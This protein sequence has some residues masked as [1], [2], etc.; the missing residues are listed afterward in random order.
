M[1]GTQADNWGSPQS[2]FKHITHFIPQALTERAAAEQRALIA[3]R[4]TK[5]NERKA[6]EEYRHATAAKKA[7]MIWAL[8]TIIINRSEHPYLARK[9]INPNGARLY[10]GC[11]V[12]A[13][14]NQYAE[15]INL[16]LINSDGSKKFL[17]RFL[18]G[19]RI[20]GCFGLITDGKNKSTILV[21]E[22]FSTGSS[23]FEAT[24]FYTIIALSARN[25][26][27]A[28]ILIAGL[29][30]ESKIVICGDND[31]SGTGQTAAKAAALACGGRYILPS[32]VGHDW[33]DAINAQVTA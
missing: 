27:E 6:D 12:I 32:T 22:G 20:K 19:G 13:I 15:I 17:K 8:A 7:Q 5:E 25:L 33:N 14:F 24:G 4:H 1:R 30:P 31:R 9:R 2:T 29:Y 11:L 3:E 16:Q 10:K 21:A 28:A 26:T 18:T 23:L